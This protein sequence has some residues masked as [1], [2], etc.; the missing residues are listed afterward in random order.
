MKKKIKNFISKNKRYLIILFIG[1]LFML[2]GYISWEVY[3]S[4]IEIFKAEEK[5]LIEAGKTYYKFRQQYY[6]KM[7]N[8]G[9][10]T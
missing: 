9:K 1:F 6:Q 7:V 4:K 8:L 2:V 10:L 5:K 3:F